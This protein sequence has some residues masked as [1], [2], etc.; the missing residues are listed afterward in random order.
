MG[1]WREALL[2]STSRGLANHGAP[3]A[4]E[5]IAR[6][7]MALTAMTPAVV[8]NGWRFYKPDVM[9]GKTWPIA[10]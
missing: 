1:P 4:N 6:Y 2:A 3:G 9:S 7:Q 10:P 8:A 5:T